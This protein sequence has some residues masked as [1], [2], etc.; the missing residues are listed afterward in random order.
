MLNDLYKCGRN[1]VYFCKFAKFSIFFLICL[2]PAFYCTTADQVQNDTSQT[3]NHAAWERFSA[4]PPPMMV[5]FSM[6]YATHS[7][8]VI[9]FGGRDENFAEVSATWSYNH[10]ENSWQQ[11]ATSRI[12]PWRVN[13]TMVYHP[14]AEK[15]LLFGGSDFQQAFND[16]WEYDPAENTW[17]NLSA[18]NSPEA[19]QMHGMIYDSARDIFIM[20]GGRRNDG[21]A[22]FNETWAFDYNAREWQNL[23]PS[24]SPPVQDHINLA[25]HPPREKTFLFSG[26]INGQRTTIAIWSFAANNNRWQKHHSP[27]SPTSDHSSFIYHP[28]SES[29][30][31][32]GNSSAGNEMETWLYDDVGETWVRFSSPETPDYREHFG[33]VYHPALDTFLLIGGFPENDNWHLTLSDQ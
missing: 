5:E 25:Y 24:V 15:V 3:E 31:L 10:Q 4:P 23:N 16:L 21:G 7:Q 13:H 9:A 12:P 14:V 6:A 33:M 32:F 20:F 28:G 8:L 18:D 27:V 19:R 1:K 29:F 26:P 22:A 17:E 2:F 30:I 11:Q